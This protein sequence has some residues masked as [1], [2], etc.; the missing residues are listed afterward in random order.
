VVSEE[1]GPGDLPIL[2]KVADELDSLA[3]MAE[4]MDDIDG[5]SGFRESAT[6]QR[7]VAMR[8]LDD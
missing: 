3:D 7:L 6:R 4:L 5:A 8:L 2:L 1:F